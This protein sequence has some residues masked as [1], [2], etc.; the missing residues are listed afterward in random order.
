MHEWG[1]CIRAMVSSLDTYDRWPASAD[2]VRLPIDLLRSYPAEQ[3]SAWKVDK[4]VRDV[5]NDEEKFIA[6]V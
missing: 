4:M 3:M 5:K 6:P 1:P 2:V